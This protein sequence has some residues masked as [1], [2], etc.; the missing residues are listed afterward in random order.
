MFTVKWGPSLD[1]SAMIA[2][3]GVASGYLSSALLDIERV[4][5][6]VAILFVGGVGFILPLNVC[7]SIL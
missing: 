6:I 3:C 7:E 2:G 1:N 5:V 4:G